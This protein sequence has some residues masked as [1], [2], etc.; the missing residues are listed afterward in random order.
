MDILKNLKNVIAEELHFSIQYDNTSKTSNCIFRCKNNKCRSRHS[1]RSNSFYSL[2][3][4]IKLRLISEI[5]K[6]FLNELNAKD[7]YDKLKNDYNQSISLISVQKIYTEIRKVFLKYYNNLYQSEILGQ[8]DHNGKFSIDESLFST[9]EE[10]R[11]IWVIGAIDN[12][13]KDFRID[14]SF[15]RNEEV[16]KAF[17]S[18]YIETGNYVITDG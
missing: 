15:N 17:L 13:T 2:F 3:P 11:Q 18:R 10:N 12:I 6:S 1:I 5:I 7:C 14:V 4:K 8:K 9:D 16:L